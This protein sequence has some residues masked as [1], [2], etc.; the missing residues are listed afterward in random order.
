MVDAHP[1]GLMLAAPR[2]GAGKTTVTLA[3]LAALKRRG[4]DIRSAKTGPDYIDPAFHSAA[5]GRPTYNFDS[6][7]MP[8]GL[9]DRLAA[10]TA[11]TADLFVVEAAMGLFDRIEGP[12][13]RRGAPADIAARYQLPVLLVLDVSGQ[14]HS[15]AAIARGFANHQPDVRI[16]GVIINRFGSERHL[17]MVKGA[18][19]E[20]GLPVLGA[21]PRDPTLA[22]K[23]RHL[24]L[25]QID[26]HPD[27]PALLT[28]FAEI[29]EAHLDLDRIIALA[30]ANITSEMSESQRP[31]TPPGQRI[32]LARDMAFTFLYAHIVDGWRAQG[33]ELVP[34]S[35]LANEAPPDDC[36]ICWLPGGYPELH[37]GRLASAEHF[38]AGLRRFA[39]TRPV[40]GE[41]G[42]YMILGESLVDGEGT[43]HAMVGLLGHSTSYAKRRLHLGYRRAKLLRP[44]PLGESG[45][46]LRGHEFH[47]AS[48]IAP[49]EDEPLAELSDGEGKPLGAGGHR[50]GNVSGTFF[51]VIAL[52]G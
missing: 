26:E 1:R 4:L 38:K 19:E 12:V 27:A 45:T 10:Q 11:E 18:I 21:M 3:L 5:T 6:W 49:G 34:F 13:G 22:V 46:L 44:S 40:H 17:R 31:L 36:D 47:Y 15:A 24:G 20:I 37:A 9:L 42:G 16:G 48:V 14:A 33:A 8:L 50:R 41:C 25:V 7:A 32:A 35:P 28:R 2:S 23:E 39:A 29:G 52:E 30:G 43:I 51:H